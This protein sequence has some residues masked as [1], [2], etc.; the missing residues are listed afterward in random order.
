MKA[1]LRRST[2]L[3]RHGV[4]ATLLLG[5]AAAASAEGRGWYLGAML[6]NTAVTVIRGDCTP[7]YYYCDSETGPSKTGYELR[8]G[9][10]LNS[11]L[12]VDFA[13]RRN[14]A[15]QWTESLATVPDVPG[16][17]DSRVVFDASVAEATAVG[18]LPFGPIFEV[19]GKGGLGFYGLSGEQSLTDL[20]GGSPLSRSVSSHGTG[21]VLGIGIGATVGKT[22]HLKLEYQ[23]LSI[24]KSFLGVGSG[25][26][27]SLDTTALGIERRFGRSRNGDG[28]RDGR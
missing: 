23:S 24:G 18:I 14:S 10:R 3:V 1:L 8:G 26:D 15:L 13:L 28:D 4:A 2:R 21:L 6:D 11:Y 5:T 17:H 7:Y 25:S 16:I 12:A 27:A 9:L 22:W 19:Y 20:T